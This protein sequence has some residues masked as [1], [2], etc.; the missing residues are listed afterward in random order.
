MNKSISERESC[1][2]VNEQYHS[3]KSRECFCY[4]TKLCS[5]ENLVLLFANNGMLERVASAFVHEHELF[6][7]EFR[8]FVRKQTLNSQ[9]F[10]SLFM[11]KRSNPQRFVP[12]LM[13]IDTKKSAENGFVIEQKHFCQRREYFCYRTKAFSKEERTFLFKNK[14]GFS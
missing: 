8:A 11:N 5:A 12:L 14:Q 10:A 3:R 4:R 1:V 7:V 13:N 2:F 9:H 6:L